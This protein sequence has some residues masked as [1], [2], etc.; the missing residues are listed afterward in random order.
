MIYTDPIAK[1]LLQEYLAPMPNLGLTDRKIGALI[2]CFK[3]VD[4]EKE[5]KD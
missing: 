2:S 4:S 5:D 1:Q 3:H